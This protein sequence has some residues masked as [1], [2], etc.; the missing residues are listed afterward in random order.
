M[1]RS[2]R[3]EKI[4]INYSRLRKLQRMQND[5]LNENWKLIKQLKEEI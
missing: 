1:T 2:E 4:K 3:Y 5:L